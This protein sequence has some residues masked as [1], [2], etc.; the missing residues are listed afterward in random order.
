MIEKIVLSLSYGKIV[1]KPEEKLRGLVPE[2]FATYQVIDPGDIICRPTDLQN[3]HTS[4]RFGIS[5]DRGI[6]TSAYMCF[7]TEDCMERRYGHLLFHSYDV[8]K[9]FYGFGS[10]LR[11]H[12]RY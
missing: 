10:G 3:D 7:G 12:S 6:I 2:S 5:N 4:L 11:G 1:V 9:I 8:K